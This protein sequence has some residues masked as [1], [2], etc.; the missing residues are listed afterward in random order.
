MN[1]EK[2]DEVEYDPYMTLFEYS[3]IV[4]IRIQQLKGGDKPKLEKMGTL[5]IIDIAKKEIDEGL[6]NIKF[7]REVPSG[8]ITLDSNLLKCPKL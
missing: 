3:K 5:N 4:E 2:S 6:V 7:K 1:E 8:Y